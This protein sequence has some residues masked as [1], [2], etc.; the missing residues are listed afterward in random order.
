MK[1]YQG[2]VSLKDP[3][4]RPGEVSALHITDPELLLLVEGMGRDKERRTPKGVGWLLW[5]WVLGEQAEYVK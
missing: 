2:A 4:S 1:G 5:V 3:D